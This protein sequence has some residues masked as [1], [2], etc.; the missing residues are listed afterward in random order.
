MTTM[1]T[2]DPLAEQP[3]AVDP[4]SIID[5]WNQRLAAQ[6]GHGSFLRHLDGNLMNCDKDN[7]E[8]IH[9]FDAFAAMHHGLDW[10]TDWG[11]GLTETERQFVKENLWNFCAAY[12]PEEEENDGLRLTALEEEVLSLSEKG[13]AALEAGDADAALNFYQA[14][15]DARATALFG[16]REAFIRGHQGSGG[17]QTTGE[18]KSPAPL[19]GR[20][21]NS[22][23]SFTDPKR[24]SIISSTPSR[25]LAPEGMPTKREEVAARIAARDA[26]PR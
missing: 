23:A 26:A 6:S 15:K 20:R 25:R 12:Q 8:C 19:Y 11:C 16:S 13:D 5:K 14:A 18:C 21:S 7:L 1:E 2:V 22:K 24:E 17:G 4:Q 3:E 10:V 9:P